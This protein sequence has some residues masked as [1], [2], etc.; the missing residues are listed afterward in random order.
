MVVN[1]VVIYGGN[2]WIGS[3]IISL[4]KN[5]ADFEIHCGKSRCDN[6]EHLTNELDV[7]KPTHIICCIGR[8]HGTVNGN[9]ISTID[10]LEHEGKLV[11]NI[12]DNLFAPVVLAKI[13]NERNIHFTYFG[14]GC[15]FDNHNDYSTSFTE[16]SQPNFF[17]SSY[18]ITKGFTDQLMK[19]YDTSCLNLRIRMPITNENNKRNLITKITSYKKICSLQNSMS[20]LDVLLPIMVRMLREQKVGTY[21]FTNPGTIEHNEILKMYK[22]IV[23]PTFTWSNF[24]LE[25]QRDVLRSDRSNNS[26]DTSKLEEFEPTILPIHDA[27]RNCLTKYRK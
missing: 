18:S 21:N 23:D 13:C 12:R 1:R 26:L 9:V 20:V 4:L 8:T 16:S 24:S 14:T 2:G 25:E 22:E 11:E 3:Q 6:V 7:I 15:I 27:V 19:L 17:G 10:Y 5:E